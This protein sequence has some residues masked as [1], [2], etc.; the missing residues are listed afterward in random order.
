MGF[1]ARFLCTDDIAGV[2]STGNTFQIP[3]G[4]GGASGIAYQDTV[5]IGSATVTNQWIGAAN[6]TSFIADIEPLDGF[7]ACVP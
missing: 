2:C 5:T 1:T 3:Y 7:R 4:E 6:F